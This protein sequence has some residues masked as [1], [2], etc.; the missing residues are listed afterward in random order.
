[1]NSLNN[2]DFR[3]LAV[4]HQILNL[5]E[6]VDAYIDHADHDPR[7]LDVLTEAIGLID[8]L[9]VETERLMGAYAHERKKM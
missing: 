2:P 9:Y 6:S 3:Q 4:T 8:A 1:M 5:M 7:A